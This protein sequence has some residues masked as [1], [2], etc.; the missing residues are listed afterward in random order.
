MLVRKHLPGSSE[1]VG[2]L[3]QYQEGSVLV[4]RFSDDLPV[5]RW[6]DDGYAADR[7]SDDGANVSFLH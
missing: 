3:I 5:I 7:L 2:D 1:A 6:R 4:A